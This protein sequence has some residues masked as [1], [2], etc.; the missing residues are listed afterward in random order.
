MTKKTL[1]IFKKVLG[2]IALLLSLYL[3]IWEVSNLTDLILL[4]QTEEETTAIV[5]EI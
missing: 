1:F 3:L 5:Y 4:K 2:I